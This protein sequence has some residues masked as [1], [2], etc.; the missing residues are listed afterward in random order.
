MSVEFDR[1]LH[2]RAR[3]VADEALK[4]WV[5]GN[6]NALQIGQRG[7]KT[8][9]LGSLLERLPEGA[10]LLYINITDD[11]ALEMIPRVDMSRYRSVHTVG[12]KRISH[13]SVDNVKF[14]DE[15]TYVVLDEAFWMDNG[16]CYRAVHNVTTR[17]LVLGSAG[18]YKWSWD[19]AIK[20]YATWD[21]NDNL[22]RHHPIIQR[23]YDENPAR[24]ERDYGY[25]VFHGSNLSNDIMVSPAHAG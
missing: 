24:A 10:K 20:K 22:P 14:L 23:A 21:L 11:K 1:I 6:P 9:I 4:L 12:G 16:E 17:I 8:T 2:P 5:Q 3:V 15:E 19:S 7:G 25:G 18:N 13:R